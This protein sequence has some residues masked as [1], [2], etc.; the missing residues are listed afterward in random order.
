LSSNEEHQT[1][2]SANHSNSVWQE[3]L[4]LI[5]AAANKPVCVRLAVN[6]LSD[7]WPLAFGA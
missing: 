2:F 1:S 6:R 5:A 4:I 7:E 3:K